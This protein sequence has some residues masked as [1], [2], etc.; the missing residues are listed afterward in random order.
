MDWG[1]A[2][3]SVITNNPTN[4]THTY[5]SPGIYTIAI[6]ENVV[7]GFP[8]ICFGDLDSDSL[9]VL[10]I[11]NWGVITWSSFDGAFN[12]CS[13]LTITATDE[14]TANTGN[15]T[16]F[17]EAWFGCSSLTSFPV[18]N[19]SSGTSFANAWSG[20]SG[21]TSF[22][23]LNTSNG[24]NF[25]GT[26]LGCSGL[27]TFPT[28]DTSHG[29]SFGATWVGC[30]GLTNF[31]SLDTS[32]GI[33][34]HATWEGCSGLT[35]FPALDTSQGTDFT[36]T[37][38]GCFSLN[39]FPLLNL[40]NMTIG[41]NCFVGDTLSTAAYSNLL[42]NIASQ[43]NNHAVTFDGGNSQYSIGTAA[44]ARNTTLITN[45]GWIITDGGQAP[46]STITNL[47]PS[48]GPSIG[49]TTVTISGTNLIGT[50]SVTFGGDAASSIAVINATSLTCV[51][52]IGAM[53]TVDVALTALG[54]TVTAVGAFTYQ[55]AAPSIV[56]TNPA[57]ISYGTG[58]SASQ[59]NATTNPVIPG[60]FVYTPHIGTV[61][62]AGV[63]QTLNVTFTPTDT[64]DYASATAAVSLNVT[65]ALLTITANNQA[66][67]AG[68]MV[69]TLTAS[70]SGFENGDGSAS[71]TTQA[72]LSTTA[73]RFSPAAAYPIT[74]SGA[75]DANYSIAFVPG[76]LTINSASR[77]ANP[78]P[79]SASN[80]SQ[81]GLGSGVS[82]IGGMLFILLRIQIEVMKRQGRSY[83][84]RDRKILRSSSQSN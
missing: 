81:C 51:T 79:I 19:T 3:T 43:N 12:G 40:G 68:S 1:D 24:T 67:V 70:Y 25:G 17:T 49:G 4:P 45:L 9:K 82:V 44:S 20:C 75:T 77:T 60:T 35:G 47:W 69:P 54:G 50:T 38:S 26:W 84:H 2:T 31:P 72:V 29:T 8:A 5:A 46:A 58:L 62:A 61:L 33:S 7:G 22:P 74:I 63:S 27:T 71:L 57:A 76:T 16:D 83:R 59:L 37:W 13:N 10:Q 15:V 80:S 56:W 21:L 64:V 30:S 41:S 55:P 66:M 28:L 36:D 32:H 34:F 42:V 48:L 11:A 6:T 53:G 23:T 65:T 78:T 52:P 14:L 39:D 73:T 18:L